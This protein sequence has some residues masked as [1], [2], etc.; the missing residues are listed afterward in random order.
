MVSESWVSSSSNHW[1]RP[2]CQLTR[3][4]GVPSDIPYTVLMTTGLSQDAPFTR[5]NHPSVDEYQD[6]IRSNNDGTQP[7]EPYQRVS[8][9]LFESWLRDLS[10]KNTLIDLRYEH[11]L[12]S[13]QETADGV[14]VQVTPPNDGSMEFQAKFA[15]ACDGA[16]SRS[17]SNLN[18]SLDGGPM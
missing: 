10:K 16:S 18:I 1:N 6:A 11:K 14:K 8:Q 12:E 2:C 17:R 15:V 4:P 5:W 9:Q 7:L 3:G 13:L